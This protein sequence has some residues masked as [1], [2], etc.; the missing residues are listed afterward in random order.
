MF[1]NGLGLGDTRS[2]ILSVLSLALGAEKANKTLTDLE[3]LVQQK[4]A[5]GTNQAIDAKIPQIRAQVHDEAKKTV[6]PLFLG[7]MVIGGLG[8]IVGVTSLVMKKRQCP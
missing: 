1:G 5:A 6:K 8:V 3:T 2:S 7:A 4:A